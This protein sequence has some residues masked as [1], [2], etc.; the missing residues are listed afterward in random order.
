MRRPGKWALSL[1]LTVRGEILIYE[2]DGEL[3]PHWDGSKSM[4][5]IVGFLFSSRLYAQSAVLCVPLFYHFV[6]YFRYKLHFAYHGPHWSYAADGLLAISIV[7]T[8]SIF[9]LHYY[10]HSIRYQQFDRGAN[11]S[12]SVEEELADSPDMEVSAAIAKHSKGQALH[13]NTE[14]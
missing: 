3:L 9:W 8:I 2:S 4:D 12:I 13:T 11:A 1:T 14:L 5:N 10:V 6:F 7:T